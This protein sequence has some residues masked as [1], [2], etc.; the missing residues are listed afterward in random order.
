M[1]LHSA[2]VNETDAQV[3]LNYLKE[4]NERFVS[5]KCMPRDTNKAD[6]ELTKSEQKPF[7][8]ILTCAD[9]RVS[10]EIFF[11]Q[12]IGDIFVVRNAGNMADRSALGSIEFAVK[13]LKAAIVVVVGH[14]QCGAVHTSYSGATGLSHN[15]QAVLDD[16]KPI[17]SG[18]SDAEAGV[19][20]NA[21]K[22]AESIKNNPVI[23]ECG[24]P[25]YAATYDVAS[26]KVNFL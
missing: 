13:H 21:K 19:V 24:A 23:K 8:A 16:I 9:S 15:L 5:N 1:K 10:P 3:A 22:Q 20:T 4:G 7:A 17:V 18:A 26:G 14:T 6:L 12:K 25:V 2:S 11:D